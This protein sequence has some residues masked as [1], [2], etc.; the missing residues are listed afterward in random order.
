MV[1]LYKHRGLSLYNM[2]IVFHRGLWYNIAKKRGDINKN[3]VLGSSQT[4]PTL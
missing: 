2:S 3:R 1:Y 4:T